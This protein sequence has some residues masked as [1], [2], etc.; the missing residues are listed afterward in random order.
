MQDAERPELL[1]LRHALSTGRTN[2]SLLLARLLAH[3]KGLRWEFVC[4]MASI[5]HNVRLDRNRPPEAHLQIQ[6]HVLQGSQSHT[7]AALHSPYQTLILLINALLC[8]ISPGSGH[9]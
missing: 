9:F 7:S 3:L 8:P 4:S 1:A 5:S 6:T 2:T